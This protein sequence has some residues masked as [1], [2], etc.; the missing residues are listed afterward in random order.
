MVYFLCIPQARAPGSP[1]VLVGTNWDRLKSEVEKSQR[2]AEFVKLIYNKYLVGGNSRDLR[3]RGLP[4]I[5]EIAFVGCPPNGKNE[6]V[7]ELR[8]TLYDVAF[9]LT[10]PKGMIS[11]NFSLYLVFISCISLIMSSYVDMPSILKWYCYFVKC[12][13]CMSS[14]S[15]VTYF[16]LI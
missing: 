3:E 7:S 5:I 14:I 1:V 11:D 10:L 2:K 15:T 13:V 9:N 12:S 8:Q 16:M 6:G 4:K